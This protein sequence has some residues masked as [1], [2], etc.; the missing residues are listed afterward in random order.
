MNID[1][2]G[3]DHSTLSMIIQRWKSFPTK[4]HGEYVFNPFQNKPLFSRVCNLSLLKT[5]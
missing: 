3:K 1:T 4:L 5:L 2:E